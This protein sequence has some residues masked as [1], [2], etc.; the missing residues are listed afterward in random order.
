[1]EERNKG[2]WRPPPELGGTHQASGSVPGG[3]GGPLGSSLRALLNSRPG[4]VGVVNRAGDPYPLPLP[5]SFRDGLIAVAKGLKPSS[6]KAG[7]PSGLQINRSNKKE[8][9]LKACTLAWGGLQVL[10]LNTSRGFTTVA[11][12]DEVRNPLKKKVLSC[13]LSNS[14][15]FVRG[16]GLS[17]DV[18]L[19]P[20]V[21][22]RSRISDLSV[23]YTGEVLEKAR[24]LS[25][26]QVEPGLPPVGKGGLLWAPDFCD[27][28]VA[29]HLN[30]ANLSRI[31]DELIENDLPYAT[32]RATQKEWNKIGSEMV[33]RGVACIIEPGDVATF[34]GK[35]ILN[36]A[37]GVIKPNKWVGDRSDN[38][39]V[40]R[41]IMDFRAA[42]SVH[43]MLPGSVSSLV[44]AAK[45]QGF[46]LNENE[47]LMASGDDLVSAFYLFK[48]P[49]CWS[50]YFSFRK[51]IP[52]GELG[53]DGNPE[54]LVYIASQVLPMGWGAA[55]TI[56]QS[57]H[58]NMALLSLALPEERE[59]H[60]ERGLPQKLTGEI[61]E[62]WNLYVD[63]LTILEVVSEKWLDHH[64][65]G[66]LGE[67]H[68]KSSMEAAY[69]E[70][71]VPYSREKA[72]SREL[73]CEKLGALLD[74]KRGRLGITT[75]R[76]LDFISLCIF[77]M[78]EEKV[79]TKW[80][81]IFLGKF[82]HLV[83]F[84][85]PI[86]SMVLHSWERVA[87]FNSGGPLT[88]KE[89]DEWFLL[90]MVLPM[91]YS[92]LAAKVSGRVAC[93]WRSVLQHRPDPTGEAG[94]ICES[95]KGDWSQALD[96]HF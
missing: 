70:L 92:D 47:V 11:T 16:D 95:P 20:E 89:V 53:L 90:C 74:G 77:I 7:M 15:C 66:G 13:L 37:F 64:N 18:V 21:P 80:R 78:G 87:H 55:V 82:V 23:G 68:L 24:W 10:A 91:Y 12:I 45:W 2:G 60:R 62:Y 9:V 67:S 54:D 14:E 96:H 39:P 79:P 49:S 85:R 42:N 26:A 22:W 30:N 44:G 33:K 41:L 36:G 76:S 69:R 65:E 40:L 88:G 6:S 31:P 25:W 59:I 72:S 86:F 17:K 71:G 46:C 3:G 51:P 8:C 83:Q 81:Q 28:W 58:R 4:R 19:R 43:R 38:R 63:D 61:S 1:M 34:K 57:M 35:M 48:L 50:R 32:V 75:A 27:G 56:M 29:E 94:S 52:R 93:S 5:P 84:R 73:R